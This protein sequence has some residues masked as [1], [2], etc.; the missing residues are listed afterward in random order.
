ML[1]L[2][3]WP[4]PGLATADWSTGRS[5]LA[6]V[7]RSGSNLGQ[8]SRTSAKHCFERN[9]GRP[10][11]CA[12]HL[13]FTP[14]SNTPAPEAWCHVGEA[15]TQTW[16]PSQTSMTILISFESKFLNQFR[17]SKQVNS[18]SN[19]NWGLRCGAIRSTNQFVRSSSPASEKFNDGSQSA[20]AWALLPSKSFRESQ[21]LHYM[22]I[23][24]VI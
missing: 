17:M 2:G 14:I 11:F 12:K 9:V 5:A 24:W 7:M 18:E 4:C 1:L 21:E 22:Q 19:T 13:D 10:H 15:C 20:E 8:C 23:P 3:L 6:S 16:V